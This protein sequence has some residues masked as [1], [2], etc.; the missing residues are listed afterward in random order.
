MRSRRA[1]GES[2]GS[3][4]QQRGSRPSCDARA[5]PPLPLQL[6]SGKS[7]WENRAALGTRGGGLV[8]LSPSF[9]AYTNATRRDH[10]AL[11]SSRHILTVLAVGKEES[12]PCHAWPPSAGGRDLP[13]V[14]QQSELCLELNTS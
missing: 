6:V 9:H 4:T 13:E 3:G 7:H 12:P 14:A 1:L 2:C 5:R 10:R 8:Q 11:P